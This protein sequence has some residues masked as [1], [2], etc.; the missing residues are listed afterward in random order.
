MKGQG[1]GGTA[2][3]GGK[4][5]SSGGSEKITKTE[6]RKT[7]AL[8]AN[9]L[10]LRA[11]LFNDNGKDKN[12][13]A[14]I[15][16][17]MQYNRNGLDLEIKF[18]SKLTDDEINWAFQLVK[19]HMEEKYDNAGYGWDDEDKDRELTEPGA[20]FLVVYERGWE[21]PIAFCHF[22]FT[23]QGEVIDT[24]D[25]ETNLYIWDIHVSEDYQRKG[26]GSHLLTICQLIGKREKMKYVSIPIM[27][28]DEIAQQWIKKSKG[29]A[30]DD[31]LFDLF[32]FDAQ[33]EGFEV[34]A[35]SL[36]IKPKPVVEAAPVSATVFD[37]K[38]DEVVKEIGD[39]KVV[40]ATDEN[41]V[42]IANED[43][44]KADII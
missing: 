37:T 33:Q 23:V 38:I 24:M 32:G 20:R 22:R 25:G 18:S 11:A 30:P 27:N 3:G 13:T 26:I 34:F 28:G 10:T 21:N 41:T 31:S 12:V 17:F 15:A 2:R 44:V 7:S 1:G 16:P 4:N 39:L 36:D 6:K 14:G 42:N 43:S 5:K 9:I 35:K 19:D 40:N 8:D 29:F